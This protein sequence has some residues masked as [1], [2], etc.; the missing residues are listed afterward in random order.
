MLKISLTRYLYLLF[1]TLGAMSSTFGQ[2]TT[3]TTQ[4]TGSRPPEIDGMLNDSVWATVAWGADFTQRQPHDGKPP[5][6]QTRFK[7]LYDDNNI[8]V[9]IR[10]FDDHPSEIIK[11][12]TRRDESDGDYVEVTFDSYFD[13]LTAFQFTVNAAGVKSDAIMTNDNNSDYTWDP[14][15]YVKTAIDS[16]GWTAEMRIPLNQLRF[17]A[18]PE[19]TWGL[20]VYRLLYGK[21][22]VSIWKHIPREESGWVSKFGEL[23]GIN[24]LVPKREIE[25]VPYAVVKAD[26]FK[27]EDGNPFA[28]GKDNKVS[29]GVDGKIGITNDFTLNYTINPDFGQ[30]EADPS[31]VNLSAFETFFQEKRPFF[32]EGKNIF[33]FKPTNGDGSNSS[34]NLFYSRRIGRRP[35]YSPDLNDNEYAK[36]PEQTN[37]LGAF[38]L[39]GKTRKGLSLGLLE[40]FTQKEVAQIDYENVRRKETVE[41]FTNY[42][43]ASL[44]QDFQKGNTVF[45]GMFTAT[46]RSIT[47]SVLDFLPASAYT[48]GINFIRNWNNKAYTFRF[49]GLFSVVSGSE[50]AMVDLQESSSHFYQRPDRDYVHV[51]SS[52]T[53]LMGQGGT[54][55]FA[56]NGKGHLRYVAWLTWRSPGLE[57]NDMGYMRES[58]IMQQVFWV[59]YQLWEPFSIFRSM[60]FNINQWSGYNFGGENIY[61]GGNTNIN[62]NFKNFWYFGSGINRDGI[63]LSVADLWGGPALKYDGGWNWWTSANT[64]YRKKLQFYANASFYWG[65]VQSQ[66]YKNYSGGFTYKPTNAL[67]FSVS[68]FYSYGNI[69]TQ[70]VTNEDV[71]SETRYIM[72]S[73]LSE[74]FGASVR[75]NLSLSPEISIQ[76]YGQ[77]FIFSG[78]YTE[79]K[80]ITSPRATALNE[81]FHLYNATELKYDEGENT[82]S[83]DENSDGTP[84][85]S[86]DNPNFNFFQ[87]RSNFVARWEYMPG[88]SIYLVWSQGRT[89]DDVIGD[90]KFRRNMDQLFAV[91]PQ[92]IFLMKVSFRIS[93]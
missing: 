51:D 87:F 80:N 53:R 64:D 12:L 46:N 34:D 73:M 66:T 28:D 89:G 43:A 78:K 60:S 59:G 72:A 33:D 50:K 54:L 63:S 4:R 25:V 10:A 31:E 32:I 86:F 70:H 65:D 62:V 83:V 68:P 57:L 23:K 88:S 1:L 75:V 92:N 55:E 77:P 42:A 82:Y 41:P 17:S 81:R 39:S 2:S 22:E 93:V 19:Q 74:S 61:K 36:T 85:L 35:H 9:G 48:G 16:L 84:E 52:L 3:Y 45:G 8:Y 56:K 76:Y 47:D 37:I 13:K 5:T 18:K 6:Y 49:N 91:H 24:N 38:K 7:I 79:F 27:K 90:F 11:R 69:Q 44:Q 40:T 29:A 30:V 14:I 20:Q 26:R 71:G 58:D 15:W 67:S 21:Q